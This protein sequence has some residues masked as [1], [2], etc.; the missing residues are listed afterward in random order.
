M[1]DA[2][3][4]YMIIG[5]SAGA[6]GAIESVR[7]L[8]KEGTIAVITDEGYA[9][10]SRPLIADFL[11]GTRTLGQILFRSSDFYTKKEVTPILDARVG[12]I[13]FEKK[14]VWFADTKRFPEPLGYEK[15]LL[16]TGGLPFVP[17]VEGGDKR[18]IF[19]FTTLKDAVTLKTRVGDIRKV[20]VVGGG[21]IGICVSEALVRLGKKVTVIE[22]QD[23]VLNVNLDKAGSELYMKRLD[24][25]GVTVIT[26]DSVVKFLGKSIDENLAGK[27]VLKSGKEIDCDL[28]VVAIGVRPRLDLVKGT[29]VKVNKGIMVDRHMRTSVPEIYACGDV[30]EAYD[31][32]W[33]M[34][35]LSPI[36]PNAY[37]GGRVAGSN[38]AGKVTEYPGSTGMT[39]F[40]YFDLPVVSAGMAILPSE[41]V[42]RAGQMTDKECASYEVIMK[43]AKDGFYRKVIL[44]DGQIKGFIMIK[45]IS[46]SS[47]LTDLLRKKIDVRGFRES[48]MVEDLENNADELVAAMKK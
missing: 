7:S 21:L 1:S 8:D 45:D 3:Y 46:G 10:Y 48:L 44:K 41:D 5:N 47:I 34:D 18:N 40:T 37:L 35:R 30:A 6:V 25:R 26:K 24:S 38:M 17:A 36:W 11:G 12:R 19:T 15:L 20:L 28:V 23:R 2:A 27:A 29:T 4:K 9:P 22:L 14:R 33:D 43:T 32:I 13:E 42:A 16:A 31:L 39:S